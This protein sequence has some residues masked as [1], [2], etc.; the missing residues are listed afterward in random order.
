[1]KE[2]IRKAILVNECSQVVEN[3]Y[4]NNR[5]VWLGSFRRKLNA[6]DYSI[7]QLID[8]VRNSFGHP[9][10]QGTEYWDRCQSRLRRMGY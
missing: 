5:G 6:Y 10:P 8:C 2:N 1:M 3:A 4:K 9:T 7:R